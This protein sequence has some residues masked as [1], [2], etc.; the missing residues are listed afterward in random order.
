MNGKLLL[1]I[2][3][4]DAL[5]TVWCQSTDH[6]SQMFTGRIFVILRA[7]AL[8]GIF[9]GN[10]VMKENNEIV[11]ICIQVEDGS[12]V[13]MASKQSQSSNFIPLKDFLD[14]WLNKIV[15]L[16]LEKTVQK[17]RPLVFINSSEAKTHV[18]HCRRKLFCSK[19][20]KNPHDMQTLLVLR[21]LSYCSW[22]VDQG[23]HG[24]QLISKRISF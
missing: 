8:E 10:V 12:S 5:T 6:N 4:I 13:W 21:R 23:I 20:H 17:D 3:L 19:R 9:V 24:K 14:C 15:S 11:P 18:R 7:S 22:W 2:L 1:Y 16:G